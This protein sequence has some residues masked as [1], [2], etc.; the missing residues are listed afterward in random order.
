[1][2]TRQAARLA[3]LSPSSCQFAGKW[4]AVVVAARQLR[5]S[6]FVSSSL[7]KLQLHLN[8]PA[9]ASEFDD[10]DPELAEDADDEEEEA[11]VEDD[12]EVSASETSEPVESVD[13]DE[14]EDDNP[15]LEEDK[16][17]EL[18]TSDGFDTDA[19]DADVANDDGA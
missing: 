5:P 9:S 3:R 10:D 4:C 13:E 18:D 8:H 15:E 11:D 16:E 12:E 17:S 2:A 19:T 7:T 1:V 6:S 14:E